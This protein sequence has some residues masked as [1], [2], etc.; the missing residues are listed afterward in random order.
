MDTFYTV[1]INLTTA[2]NY[3]Q[4][5]TVNNVTLLKTAQKLE[6]QLKEEYSKKLELENCTL[7]DPFKLETALQNH[8]M[9]SILKRRRNDRFHVVSTWNTRGVFERWLDMKRKT[10]LRTFQLGIRL[11]CIL[12]FFSDITDLSDYKASKG[13][14]CFKQ[15]WVWKMLCRVIGSLFSKRRLRTFSNIRLT[16]CAFT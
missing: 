6:A 1:K 7:P 11:M 3:Y 15:G 13:Y 9:N 4:L 16:N 12:N 14:S 10:E 8:H 2:N 5:L